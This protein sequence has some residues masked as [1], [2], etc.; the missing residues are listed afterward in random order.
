MKK[1]KGFTMIELMIV[2]AIMAILAAIAI[3]SY[4]KYV[5]RANRTEAVSALTDLS[6]REERFFYSNNR[7]TSG[8]AADL[9]GTSTMGTKDYTFA[10]V[11]SAAS[12]SPPTYAITATP[13]GVQ[14]QDDAECQSMSVNNI[15]VRSS[16]G[17]TAN[18]PKCWGSQ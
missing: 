8:I 2:V 4:R 13:V 16:T 9:N 1:A 7:Y 15:G 6:N 14:L 12:V 3:P 10:V 18:N 11:A 17:T 5:I